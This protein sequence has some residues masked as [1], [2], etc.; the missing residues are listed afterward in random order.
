VFSELMARKMAE[1]IS[2]L[3]PDQRKRYGFER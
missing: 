2:E 3:T 1:K